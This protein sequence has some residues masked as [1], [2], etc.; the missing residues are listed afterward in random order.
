[1]GVEEILVFGWLVGWLVG[2]V[3]GWVGGLDSFLINV[4][5]GGGGWGGVECSINF[6]G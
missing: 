4:C 5:V 3:G 1:M 6:S 2:W